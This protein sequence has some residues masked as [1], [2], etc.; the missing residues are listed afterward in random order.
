MQLKRL[1]EEYIVDQPLIEQFPS[2]Q[3]IHFIYWAYCVSS[4]GAYGDIGGVTPFEKIFQIFAMIFFRIYFT[5]ISAE[6][7]NLF[8]SV[9]F[10]FK[11]NLDK[12][13]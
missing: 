4:S 13:N 6:I 5:F 1:A 3:Y 11:V 2:I 7:A 8:A 12:V 9:Y 10:N